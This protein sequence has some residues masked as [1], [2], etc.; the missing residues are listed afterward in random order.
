MKRFIISALSLVALSL[1]V[2]TASQTK[3]VLIIG[4]DG[5]RSDALQQAS[6]PNIDQ[7]IATGFFTYDSWHLGYTV[8]GPSWSAMFTGVWHQKNGVTDNSYAGSNFAN[9]PYYPHR[10]KEIKPNLYAVQV[11]DWAPMS[12]Q[13]TNEQFDQKIIR[14]ENDVTAVANAAI[15]Q[16]QNPNLDAM[17]VY[18]AKVDNM[19]HGS[20]FSPSNPIYM[21]AIHEVDSAI[22]RVMLALHARPNYNNE[23]WL[24]LI[25]TDHG[26][27]GTS[28]GG[29]SDAERHIWWIGSGNNVAQ[30]Q[31]VAVQDPGSYLMPSNPLNPALLAKTPVQTD[32][33]VTAI[34]H[35]VSDALDS[36]AFAQKRLDWNLDGKS[37]LDSLITTSTPVDTSGSD[38]TH[39]T[40]IKTLPSHHLNVS[41]YPNPAHGEISFWFDGGQGNTFVSCTIYNLE[42][43]LVKQLEGRSAMVSKYKMNVDLS[44]LPAG[45][46]FV[47]IVA[48]DKSATKPIIISR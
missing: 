21:S 29:N 17:T 25:C 1:Q 22:G 35:L 19:G 14:T 38:T 34:H 15:N 18:F 36:A 9:Y 39:P 12:T 16:L 3:K 8:S 26:G 42:G 44:A 6:T 47:R 33:A 43:R 45:Q 24:V 7:L 13:V 23:D 5:L 20:G 28:H 48:D 4:I 40:G 2:A 41:I 30:K 46:Y 32:I 27:T 37:W 10:V 31:L 11:V